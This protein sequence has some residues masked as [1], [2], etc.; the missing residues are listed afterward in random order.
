MASTLPRAALVWLLV[1]GA[2]MGQVAM[3][4]FPASEASAQQSLETRLKRIPDPARLRAYMKRM[5]AGPHHAGSAGSRAVAEYAL[6]LFREWGLE[7]R[8]ENFEALIPYPASVSVEMTAPE[9]FR[10]QL[11][12]PGLAEDKASGDAGLLAVYNAYSGQGDVTAPLVYVNYGVPED[13]AQLRRMGIDVRGKVVIARYGKS[14]RGTKPKLA[15]ENGAAACIIYSDPRD[16]GFFQGDVYPKGPYRPADGVQRGSVMDMPLYVGDPLTPGWASEPGARRLPRAQ[17]QAILKIPVAPMSYGDAAKLMRRLGG[18]VAPEEWRGAMGLTYHVGPGPAVVRVKAEF[19][20]ATR[21]LYNVIATIAG[22]QFRDQWVV[23]GNH[24]DAWGPGAN[25]PA[26]GAA[27]LLETARTLAELKKTGWRPKRTIKLALWDGEEFG[28][29]G[30]TEWVEK[31]RADL[32]RNTVAYLNT[33]S[34]GNGKLVAGGSASLEAF[35][36]QAAAD[37]GEDGGGR[38]GGEA[39]R[40]GTLGAGSDYVAFHNHVG[41]SSLNLG[42]GGASSGV[43]HSNYDTMDWYLRFSD[44]DFSHGR[45]LAGLMAAMLTRFAEAPLLPFEFGRLAGAIDLYTLDL[46]RETAGHLELGEL[47]AALK[48]LGAAARVFEHEYS[49]ALKRGGT[50]EWKRDRV[51]AINQTIYRGERALTNPQGLPGRN[52]YRHLITA[53]GLYT[54]YSARSLPGI[55]EAAEAGR[56]AEANQ[57]ARLVAQA[58][59]TLSAELAAAAAAIKGLP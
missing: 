21:P 43:Y 10:A 27:V 40:L 52:W 28:L 41:V 58:V 42:F 49:A 16:D 6:G 48:K 29:I 9:E 19:D 11:R 34:T 4:G 32:D 55:R 24:H 53:P 22:S 59:K 50:R 25:D 51:A 13:Y 30:S 47:K 14:W 54:G 3:R 38:L 46:E 57:Q 35:F 2:A 31:H 36:A 17:A 18:P 23:Y 8:I 56:W 37:Y 39:T 7:A 5:T 15:Q 1:S 44:G 26:S 12:E 33:D 20:W 45:K